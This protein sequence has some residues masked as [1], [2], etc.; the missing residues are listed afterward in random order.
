MTASPLVKVL[1]V[2]VDLRPVLP[3]KQQVSQ[4][5]GD[6]KFWALPGVDGTPGAVEPPEGGLSSW[7]RTT[8]GTKSNISWMSDRNCCTWSFPGVCQDLDLVTHYIH[9]GFDTDYCIILIFY[10]HES[11]SASPRL[12]LV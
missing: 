7:S 2:V 10:P 6:W 8:A 4:V 11:P 5:S 12:A 3:R 9:N 1:S